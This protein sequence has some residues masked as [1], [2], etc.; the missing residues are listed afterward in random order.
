LGETEEN[1]Q[2][3]PERPEIPIAIERE[4]ELGMLSAENRRQGFLEEH[5]RT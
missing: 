2:V 1:S 5:R 4:K 3:F